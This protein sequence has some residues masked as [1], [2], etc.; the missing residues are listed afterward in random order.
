MNRS[1]LLTK[2]HHLGPKTYLCPVVL[3]V[4]TYGWWRNRRLC[5]EWRE[6]AEASNRRYVAKQSK[7]RT[8]ALRQADGEISGNVGTVAWYRYYLFG[9]DD[10]LSIKRL[11]TQGL[12]ALKW[13]RREA[14]R[15]QK[16]AFRRRTR[17][18]LKLTSWANYRRA[19]RAQGE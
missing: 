5:E 18:A 3:E 6:S 4:G 15:V 11:K 16:E 1:V 8:R 9:K 19:L 10:T 13:K 17:S 2:P 14:R 12:E 7:L